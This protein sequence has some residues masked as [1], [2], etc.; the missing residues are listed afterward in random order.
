LHNKHEKNGNEIVRRKML[1]Y[2]VLQKLHTKSELHVVTVWAEFKGKGTSNKS[3]F[4]DSNER[5]RDGKEKKITR[6]HNGG[7][8]VLPFF[9]CNSLRSISGENV[10]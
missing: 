1:S 8:L 2:F 7:I 6:K 10:T 5:D 3:I 9:A 4:F